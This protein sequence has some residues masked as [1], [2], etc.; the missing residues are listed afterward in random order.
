MSE[1]TEIAWTN[2]TLNL[3]SGCSKISAGCANC[4]AANL[5]PA[6]RRH[7]EWG[8]TTERK[9]AP[10]SYIAQVYAWQR[11]AERTGVRERVFGPS[12]AD[13]FEGPHDNGKEGCN[14]PRPD[15]LPVLRRM[16]NL[17]VECPTLDFQVLTKRPWNAVA[18]WRDDVIPGAEA[19]WPRNLWIGTSVENQEAANERVPWLVQLP[20]AVRFLSMEPMLDYVD[21]DRW[22]DDLSADA[23][24]DDE[25]TLRGV[26]WV[27]IGGES[28]NRARPFDPEWARAVVRS[29]AWYGVPAFV[30]QMGS[31]WAAERGAEHKKG[32]DPGEWDADLRVREM[33]S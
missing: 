29:C 6:M 9:F 26:Q 14:G 27:I 7:A 3:L 23:D 25:P 5:P 17:A 2:H 20:A 15:Y 16:F 33:P 32:G 18:W 24:G 11:R 19:F 28:G 22:L 30:K 1:N 8:P 31:V 13:P 4:Y 12:V 21:V 10:E